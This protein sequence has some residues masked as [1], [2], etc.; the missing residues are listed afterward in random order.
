MDDDEVVC[1]C[2]NVTVQDIK[3]AIRN[4]AKSFEEVQEVTDV[5][6]GCGNC[7]DSVKE[8]VKNLLEQQ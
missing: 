8:L 2:M 3:V 7:T 1:G 4:G 5:S 6:N